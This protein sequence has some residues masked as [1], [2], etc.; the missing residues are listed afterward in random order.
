V[1]NHHVIANA[2]SI[3]V[4]LAARARPHAAALHGPVLG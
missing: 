4:Q 1:T 2:D 3:R